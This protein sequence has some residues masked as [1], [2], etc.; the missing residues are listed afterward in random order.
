MCCHTFYFEIRT[1]YM[2]FSSFLLTT[3]TKCDLKYSNEM[4]FI[5]ITVNIFRP[6]RKK[7]SLLFKTFLHFR[8]F[9]EIKIVIKFNKLFCV[10]SIESAHEARNVCACD[11]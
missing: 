5:P 8:D 3:D 2:I 6:V 4:P 11:G 9:M 1:F 10:D 7:N